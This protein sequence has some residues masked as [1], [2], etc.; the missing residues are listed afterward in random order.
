MEFGALAPIILEKIAKN[1]QYQLKN[2]KN[3]AEKVGKDFEAM[4][5]HT[6]LSTMTK[7][8]TNNQKNR[9][10]QMQED[11]AWALMI[12]TV[13]QEMAGEN[14]LKIGEMIE[15]QNERQE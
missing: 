13:S 9:V 10:N 1:D 15:H 5:Y 3:S 12:Q 7:S 11:W 8:I 2:D 6:I 4:F 14:H